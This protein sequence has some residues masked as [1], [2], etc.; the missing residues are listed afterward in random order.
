MCITT[1]HVTQDRQEV[2]GVT[3][4]YC[5]R[6]NPGAMAA[7]MMHNLSNEDFLQLNML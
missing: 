4:D 5:F 1:A 6:L 2:R 3:K 7:G